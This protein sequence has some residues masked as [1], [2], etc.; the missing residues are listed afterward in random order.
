MQESNQS[1]TLVK[2]G[3][4]RLQTAPDLLALATY[5][6]HKRESG[7]SVVVVHGGGPEISQLHEQLDVPFE[8][9][10]GL[11]VTTPRGMTLTTMV[12]C[13]LVNKRV[14]ASLLT[15]QVPAFGLSG[16]DG[17][18]L[19]SSFLNQK[20]YGYVGTPPEVS[21]E[22]LHL[23]MN[24]GHVPIVAPVSLG[25]DGTPINVNADDAAHAIAR[26]M[27]VD[28]LEF[29]SD[30]PGVKGHDDAVIPMVRSHELEPLI[31]KAVVTGGMIPKL[32]GA[33]LAVKSG[34]GRVRI[35]DLS[36]MIQDTAT[37]VCS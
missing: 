5:I 8:K 30:I 4:A 9:L 32:R 14:V 2:V 33:A 15:H 17:R 11:R 34:V 16:V 28:S 20:R 7:Q 3:G 24:A 36:G 35:G 19:R 18:I 23:L 10:D 27:H 25:P 37:V 29:I 1:I 13:G 31:S 12:L 22:L 26:A 6:G 21:T